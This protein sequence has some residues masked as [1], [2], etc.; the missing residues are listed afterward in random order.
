V[1]AIGG[2]ADWSFD[3]EARRRA[4]RPLG[5]W[6]AIELVAKDGQVRGLL[7]GTLVTTI[8]SHNYTEPGNIAFQVQG[9]KM[10]WRNLRIRPE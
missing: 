4:I 1:F 8:R 3:L 10:Y 5:E 2:Q 9:A 7:N 6:N